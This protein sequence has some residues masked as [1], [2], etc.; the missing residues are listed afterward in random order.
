MKVFV[1]GYTFSMFGT[2]RIYT[3][4]SVP[5]FLKT[6]TDIYAYMQMVFEKLGYQKYMFS[7]KRWEEE[8]D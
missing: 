4:Y 8:D 3:E 1:N 5:D 6:D 2:D 7:V